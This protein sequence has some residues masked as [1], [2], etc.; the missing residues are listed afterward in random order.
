[1]CR[2]QAHSEMNLLRTQAEKEQGQFEG[3]WRELTR[4]LEQDRKMKERMSQSDAA[5]K[6]SAEDEEKLKKK[7]QRSE[8]L[9]S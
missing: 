1:L 4:L 8:G 9:L 2:D 5:G 3:E 6:L 7:S